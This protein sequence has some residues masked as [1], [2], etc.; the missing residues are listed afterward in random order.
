VPNDNVAVGSL[1]CGDDRPRQPVPTTSLD[2]FFSACDVRQVDYLK[3]EAEGAEYDSHFN[4][5]PANLAR[6][7]RL[8]IEVHA[9]RGLGHAPADLAA[10][11]LAQGFQVS[12]DTRF[13]IYW[14]LFGT[15][16]LRAW[17]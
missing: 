12:G 1:V 13:S 10:F 14:L 4:C 3:P 5:R 9:I 8:V 2:D 17:R 6:A 16:M 15:M 7:L 11:L